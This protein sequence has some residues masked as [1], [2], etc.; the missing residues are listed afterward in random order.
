MNINRTPS[1]AQVG[2]AADLEA[3]VTVVSAIAECELGGLQPRV[4]ITVDVSRWLF[5][6]VDSRPVNALP[7]R[8]NFARTARD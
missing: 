2:A 1:G 3:E 6:G 8:L 7:L 4:P 5:D